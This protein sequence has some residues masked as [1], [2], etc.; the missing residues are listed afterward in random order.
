MDTLQNLPYDTG[1]ITMKHYFKKIKEFIMQPSLHHLNQKE[2]QHH[3]QKQRTIRYINIALSLLLIILSI[4]AMFSL[5]NTM[6]TINN[7]TIRFHTGLTIFTVFV[8]TGIIFSIE[9]SLHADMK[10]LQKNQ[11]NL[12]QLIQNRG[13]HHEDDRPCYKLD[14]I[15]ELLKKQGGT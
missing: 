4:N 14:T 9:L 12:I 7:E 11:I 6:Y 10:Q 1:Y 2:L 3:Y 5:F 13:H 8:L 15:I